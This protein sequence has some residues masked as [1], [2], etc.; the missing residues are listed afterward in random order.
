MKAIYFI[1]VLVLLA[2]C[3]TTTPQDPLAQFYQPYQGAQTNW[4]TGT[5]SFVTDRYGVVFYYG[6]PTFHYTIVG[7][8]AHPN[9][10]LNKLA[11]SARFHGVESVCL[12][13]QQFMGIH[14]NPSV[15]FARAGVLTDI[16]GDTYLQPHSQVTA[17]LIKPV[18]PADF[19]P[20]ASSPLPVGTAST[21]VVH[22]PRQR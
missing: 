2:G 14:Q 18:N 13:E 12:A 22:S 4:P 9:L 15:A 3:D 19:T 17:Y 21:N 6:L 5:G 16:P 11:D 8:Y 7:R 10:P 1:P 20:P